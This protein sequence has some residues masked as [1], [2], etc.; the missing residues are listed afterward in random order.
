MNDEGLGHGVGMSENEMPF[1]TADNDE[2]LREGMVIALDVKTIGS[3][4]EMIHSVDIYELTQ[5][6]NRKLSDFRD[7]DSLYLINGVRSTH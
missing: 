2:V 7:W 3:K 5:N 1:L 4:N 6:G